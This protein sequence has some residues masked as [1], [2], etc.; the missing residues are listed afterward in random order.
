MIATGHSVLTLI[1][2]GF[3]L[4]EFLLDFILD[5]LNDTSWDK[6]IPAE[7]E[8][9]YDD[10]QYQ[11]AQSYHRELNKLSTL[12]SILSTTLT[13]LFLWFKGFAYLQIYIEQLTINPIGQA[14][15]FFGLFAIVSDIISLPFELYGTFVIE[16]KYGFNKMSL[17]TFVADKLKGYLLG[18]VIGAA[19][20]SLFVLFYQYAGRMFWVYA[21]ILFTVFSL[22]F[23]FIYTSWIMPLFNKFTPLATGSLREKIEAFSQ[24]VSFP[25]TKIQVMDGS[26]RSSK[27]NAFFSGFGKKKTIVLFD[28]LINEQTDDELLSVLAH[29]VGHY[30]MKHIQQGMIISILQMGLMLFLLSLFINEPKLSEALGY[31]TD[32][33]V[34]HL[35]LIAFALLYSPFSTLTGIV[36]NYIS[37][38]NEFEADNFAKENIGTGEYLI[39]GLKKLSVNNL[40]NLNPHPA[41]VFVHFS[42]PPLLE[43]VRNLM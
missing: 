38:K 17:K 29:E 15:V 3:I 40:S 21:W 1:I 27:A 39:S 5:K 6:P 26:K 24:K 25:L 18:A 7:L 31:S 41:Y 19:L 16:E 4:L 43:R 11:K 36:M 14:L 33:P 37:R 32:K 34:F 8:G 28:T 2:I 20:L 22:F 9:L 42:H 30:K 35:G 13:V 23:V 10:T 12:T